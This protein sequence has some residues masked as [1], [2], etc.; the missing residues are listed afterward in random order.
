MITWNLISLLVEENAHHPYQPSGNIAIID[1]TQN[2][3]IDQGMD[4]D[5]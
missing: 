5:F 3:V 2:I 1:D 4:D